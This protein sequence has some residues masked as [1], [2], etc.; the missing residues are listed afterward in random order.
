MKKSKLVSI[1]LVVII[2]LSV[3]LVS[4]DVFAADNIILDITSNTAN[5]ASN[6]AEG[7]TA[8]NKTN[9]AT[10]NSTNSA[11]NSA[12]NVLKT[13]NANNNTTNSVLPDTGAGDTLPG[14]IFVVVL[15]ISAIY[16]YNKIQ[17]YKN[18]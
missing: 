9:N 2:S 13:N 10:N 16:A 17:Y 8:S 12:N 4:K 3:L 7:N 1:V 18:I 14:I 6:S 15:G 5:K 11:T